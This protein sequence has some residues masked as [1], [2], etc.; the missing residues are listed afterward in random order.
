MLWMWSIEGSTKL[1]RRYWEV[2]D[3]DL[4]AR[5]SILR[6]PMQVTVLYFRYQDGGFPQ[7]PAASVA[8]MYDLF[9]FRI[10]NPLREVV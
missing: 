6:R 9:L 10:W 4:S 8:A 2:R 3:K 1:L 5:T 7:E